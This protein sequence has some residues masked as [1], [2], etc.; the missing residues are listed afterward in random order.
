MKRFLNFF[1]FLFIISLLTPLY[2]IR[3]STSILEQEV[4]LGTS[5]QGVLRI[6]TDK[7]ALSVQINPWTISEDGQSIIYQNQI[8]DETWLKI[9]SLC[10]KTNPTQNF[11]DVPYTLLLNDAKQTEKIAH[12]FITEIT[13]TPSDQAIDISVGLGIPVYVWIKDLPTYNIKVREVTYNRDK[14][15]LA[16]LIE[17]NGNIHVRPEV[18]MLI[19]N[20]QNNTAPSSGIELTRSWPILASSKRKFSKS[21]DLSEGSYKIVFKILV[22][23][24]DGKAYSKEQTIFF[25]AN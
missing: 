14:K 7:P 18:N 16:V 6:Y 25:L 1:L 12:L 10:T 5:F 17:N 9:P 3:T 4:V 15:E 21:L 2:A 8:F 24:T 20:T 22:R 13:P 19:K 23:Q 11:I